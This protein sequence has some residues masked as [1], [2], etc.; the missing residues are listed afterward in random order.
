ME[1]GNE[2]T[3]LEMMRVRRSVQA[4]FQTQVGYVSGG[5]FNP[6]AQE[7]AEEP[8]AASDDV[9]PADKPSHGLGAAPGTEGI[10]FVQVC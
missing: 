3:F 2:D 4:T 10:K 7:P 8:A 6:T 5:T 9:E 1:H